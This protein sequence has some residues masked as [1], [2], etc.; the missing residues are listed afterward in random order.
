MRS[1]TYLLVVI[2]LA[3]TLIISLVPTLASAD[4]FKFDGSPAFNVTYPRGS[5]AQPNID[6]SNVWSVK[7]PMGVIVRAR[8]AP[9]PEGMDTEGCS[10]KVVY[11]WTH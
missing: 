9:I 11:A 8:V 6:P 7:T 4:E 5:A 2:V 10:R 1:K 3:S